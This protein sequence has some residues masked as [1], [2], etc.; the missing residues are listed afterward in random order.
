MGV[1]FEYGACPQCN[2][3]NPKAIDFC[4]DCGA[5]LPWAKGAA[6]KAAKQAPAAS[7]MSPG[8]G[9]PANSMMPQAAPMRPPVPMSPPSS[10][11]GVN[12][13][14]VAWGAMAVQGFGGLIFVAGCFLWCGN[15]FGFFRTFPFAGYLTATV[16]GAIW[17]AGSSMD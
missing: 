17:R 15:V 1:T 16:G 10:S 4:R 12:M 3:Q 13:G 11:G 9:A 7:P 14:N 8:P 5:G 6:R 2:Q